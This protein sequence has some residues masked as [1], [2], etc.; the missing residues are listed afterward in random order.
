MRILP[1]SRRQSGAALMVFALILVLGASWML[2]SALNKASSDRNTS[3]RT[4]SGVALK[5]AKE[6]LIGYVVSQA[7]SASNVNPGKFPCPENPANP[8]TTNEGIAATSCTLPAIG[9]FPWRT[10]GLDKLTDGSGEPL[11]YVLSAGWAGDA[12]TFKINSDTP[13]NLTLD[14]TANAAIALIVAPGAALIVNPNSNQ[15]AAGCAARTQTRDAKFLSGPPDYR[16]YL[17]CQNGSSPIDVSFVTTV[18]DNTANAVFNDQVTAVTVGDIMPGLDGVIS[19]RI[20]TDIA[21][22]LVSEYGSA[23]WNGSG[24]AI[25]FPFAAAFGDASAKGV[26]GTRAG[27]LPVT[28]SKQPGSTT[29]C[30]SATDTRCD[31]TFVAWKTGSG[32]SYTAPLPITTAG[33]INSISVPISSP[34]ITATIVGNT[35]DTPPTYASTRGTLTSLN[36]SGTTSTTIVCVVGYGRACTG[37]SSPY[38]TT[39]GSRT[40]TPIVRLTVRALN[41]A[42]AIRTFDISPLSVARFRSRTTATSYGASPLGVL[43]SDGDAD[44]TTEWILPGKD[45]TSPQTPGSCGTSTGYTITI[46]I[47]LLADHSIINSVSTEGWF[48]ANDWHKVTYFAIGSGHA[49]G[50]AGT[51]S[52][53]TCLTVTG[54][55]AAGAL[56]L[57]AGRD[58]LVPIP[59]PARRPSSTL[60]HYLEGANATVDD[61]FETRAVS[62]TFND[63]LIRIYP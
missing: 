60:A 16:D 20:E 41:V 24:S 3:T 47:S 36:C 42:R 6:G 17:E 26:S 59:N 34:F 11:W 46:P 7:A 29:D 55:S 54:G 58:L 51:C 48:V 28:Y 5:Q 49:P 10:L 25:R 37:Y 23:S 21:P 50:G 1:S 19:K 33:I 38:W 56:F 15:L 63:R 44:I 43:R 61:T 32:L 12:G 27:L 13:G 57:Y 18:V 45:C 31:P 39:C 53:S 2:V 9:R 22:A 8:G 62:S 52:G 35:T 14:G 40:E 30:V 4:Q